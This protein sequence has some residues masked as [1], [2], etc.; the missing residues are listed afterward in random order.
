MWPV[1]TGTVS[2]AGSPANYDGTW[3]CRFAP[4]NGVL[5]WY[6]G[7][8]VTSWRIDYVYEMW[9]FYKSQN[10]DNTFFSV[11]F[12]TQPDNVWH[13]W[14]PDYPAPTEWTKLNLRTLL[15]SW[16][17][18]NTYAWNIMYITGQQ[19]T[20]S[21][22]MDQFHYLYSFPDPTVNATVD[23]TSDLAGCGNWVFVNEKYYS[24]SVNATVAANASTAINYAEINMTIPT[25]YFPNGQPM[26]AVYTLEN[27]TMFENQTSHFIPTFIGGYPD[28][29]EPPWRLKGDFW[30]D[31]TDV[32][33][34][35]VFKI[36][37]TPACLDVFDPLDAIDITWK[38][39]TT[40]GHY[41]YGIERGVFRIYN[42][43]GF[44][45]NT[46]FGWNADVGQYSGGPFE[47]RA[48]NYSWIQKNIYFKRLQHIKFRP[49]FT[50][51]SGWQTFYVTYEISV[52]YPGK[53]WATML[54]VVLEPE[55]FASGSQRW[56][57]WSVLW[58]G[59][60]DT[61]GMGGAL[62]VTK[63]D[64]LYSYFAGAGTTGTDVQTW[65][66][67]DFWFGQ[68]NA[69]SSVNGRLNAVFYP[70]MDNA[71]NW[72]HI[73]TTGWGIKDDVPKETQFNGHL[74]NET[75]SA[76]LFSS[77]IITM[78]CVT[79]KLE[80]TRS[81]TYDQDVE[82]QRFAVW[83]VTEGRQNDPLTGISTPYFDDTIQPSMPNTGLFGLVAVGFARLGQLIADNIVYGG[84]NLWGLFVGFLDT[85][86]ASL[87]APGLFTNLFNWLSGAW[88]AFI[89]SMAYIGGLIIPIF[90]FLGSF[91][92]KLITIA[93]EMMQY[94]GAM[95]G[96]LWSFLAGTYTSGV[97]IYN[98]LGLYQWL[99]LG[100]IIYPL[101]LIILWDEK[102]LGAVIWELNLLKDV[103]VTIGG[104][105][106][107]GIEL[108]LGVVGRII[109]SIPVVE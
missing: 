5:E 87:G 102:G 77:N 39:Q 35:V 96:Y 55:V 69:S 105:L 10:L 95:F 2:V 78:V 51:V 91:L 63:S 54:K 49:E 43:G 50:F 40:T 65:L 14:A 47:V 103:A 38:I 106:L 48:G 61:A 64:R 79:E 73:L 23:F 16:N 75:T 74:V 6:E 62:S 60:N 83:D 56:L 36:W 18:S 45:M 98:D 27:S 13:T 31:T 90:T 37:F 52:C 93:I 71:P 22:Y 29:Q 99:I 86:A 20:Y 33:G 7:D 107:R 84:L 44:A 80:V 46:T 9:V 82:L 11:Q 34:S 108:F 109:E 26:R 59:R 97:N 25:V 100:I 21:W 41:D 30:N 32:N 66:W 4:S 81:A 8:P 104:L 76:N 68:E 88:N 57:N 17:D 42:K 28:G 1:H 72:L 24:F 89:N 58:Y 101:H 53:D 92:W 85:V 70:M 3:G 94:W 12:F 67:C 19:L 15:R